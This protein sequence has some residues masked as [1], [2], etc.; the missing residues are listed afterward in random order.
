[1]KPTDSAKIHN[2][3]EHYQQSNLISH[4]EKNVL[5]SVI[6]SSVDLILGQGSSVHGGSVVNILTDFLGGSTSKNTSS[7]N[8]NGHQR[9]FNSDTDD[10]FKS[11]DDGMDLLSS[12]DQHPASPSVTMSNSIDTIGNEFDLA[13]LYDVKST[14]KKVK[15]ADVANNEGISDH[16]LHK[17]DTV[18]I[19]NVN[20]ATIATTINNEAEN[21]AIST[22]GSKINSGK[23]HDGTLALHNDINKLVSA[24]TADP[25]DAIPNSHVPPI[26]KSAPNVKTKS[27]TANAPPRVRRRRPAKPIPARPVKPIPTGDGSASDD[28]KQASVP[29]PTSAVS[30]QRQDLDLSRRKGGFVWDRLADTWFNPKTGYYFFQSKGLYV[31]L[32]LSHFVF[33]KNIFDHFASIFNMLRC[34]D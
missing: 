33:L 28:I 34:S 14:S 19:S 11:I 20:T 26:D 30:T 4:L 3:L 31:P 29:V 18:A 23:E 21:T 25:W 22:G 7:K 32:E 9:N 8:P 6:D 17:S 12:F 15:E 24:P 5:S 13:G 2:L 27:V 10:I 1:M 16:N